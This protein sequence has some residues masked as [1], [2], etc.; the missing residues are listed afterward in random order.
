M[1]V[2]RICLARWADAL[3]AS[4]QAARWNSKG[5]LVI[6]TAANRA[7][8]CLENVLFRSG[9]G[10]MKAFRVLTIEIPDDVP[11][12]IFDETRLPEH[13]VSFQEVDGTQAFGD[14][15]L[16]SGRTA[17]LKIPSALL[18]YEFNFLINPNHEDFARIRLLG[19]EPFAF[20]PG[21]RT[22]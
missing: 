17:V 9:E 3:S 13:W 10:P 4:G 11:V 18:P 1:H 15:W 5:K 19:S 20:A 22:G 6:Y 8:S 21:L 7:L 2:Y 14:E 16:R 12:E